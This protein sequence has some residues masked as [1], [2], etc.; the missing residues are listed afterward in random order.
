MEFES[1][2]QHSQVSATCP[3][4]EPARS[5]PYHHIPPPEDSYQYYPPIYSWVF[6]V[7]SFPQAFPLKRCINRSFSPIRATRPSHLT[8]LYLITQIILGHEYRTLSTSLCSCLH[9]PVSPSLLGP[10]IL[11]NALFSYTLSLRS[12]LDVSDQVSHPYKTTGKFIVLCILI[13]MFLDSKLRYSNT[14][15]IYIFIKLYNLCV[16]LRVALNV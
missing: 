7:V 11:L 10:N 4:L 3:Y 16:V 8:L 2:L 6:Q 13:F 15:G 5:S 1:S 14:V 9:S 12:S